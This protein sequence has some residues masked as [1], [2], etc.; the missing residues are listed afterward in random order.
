MRKQRGMSIYGLMYVAITLGFVG[1]VGLKIFNPMMEYLAVKKVFATMANQELRDGSS[2]QSIRIGFDK[3]ATIDDIRSFK[4]A[5]LE[6]G[7]DGNE[8]TMS[9][10]WS[11]KVPLFWVMSLV[12]DFNV[13]A[14]GG[15]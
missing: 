7:K 13:T 15:Q 14:T 4:S 2:V 12:L 9:V 10:S 3:R 1:Y 6:I 5:D 11:T 8:T